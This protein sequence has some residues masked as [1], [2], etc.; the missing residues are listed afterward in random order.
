MILKT[1][2]LRN[3]ILKTSTYIFQ[4]IKS[5]AASIASNTL[6]MHRSQMHLQ[7]NQV[8]SHTFT[9][10]FK[11]RC[12]P[13]LSLHTHMNQPN[14]GQGQVLLKYF[15]NSVHPFPIVR[16]IFV[17]IGRLIKRIDSTSSSC[18]HK[19]FRYKR[20]DRHIEP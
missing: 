8:S 4:T 20:I 11:C 15:S 17:A 7:V 1:C 3:G 12:F 14:Q 5:W 13:C 10:I 16:R 6:Y 18:H 9:R 2:I 19:S